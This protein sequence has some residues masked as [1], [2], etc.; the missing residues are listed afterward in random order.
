MKILMIS[1]V[2][3][4]KINGAAV[5]VSNMMGS[6]SRR[7]HKVTLVTRREE[8]AAAEETWNE[9]RVL[10]V[11]RPGFALTRRMSLA[12]S[13]FATG[14]R[15]S[16]E[17][18]PDVIHS[19]GFTSLLAGA[20][21]GMIL[22]RPVVVSF[23]GIQRLWSSQ[24]RWR[25]PIT[26]DL[27]YPIEK[28]LLRATSAILAQSSL[29]RDVVVQ[30][31]SVPARK[32]YV[33]PNPVDVKKFGFA[34]LLA[35]ESQVVLF[36]GSLMRVHGPDILVEAVPTILTGH[37]KVKVVLVG[38]GPLKEG[39]ER[40]I[41]ELGLG[42]SVQLL[43]EVGDQTRLSQIYG[44]A[45]VVVIPLRYTGYILSLV[46]EE[47]MAS[48]R[49]FVTTMTLDEELAKFGVLQ[50]G[51]NGAALGT[52]ISSVLDWKETRYDEV[53]R[54]ARAYAEQNFSF[55]AV[56][57]ALESVYLGATTS[58]RGAEVAAPA[59]APSPMPGAKYDPK[60]FLSTVLREC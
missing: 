21:L 58:R 47:A 41:A 5:A 16:R 36:V 28:T 60:R 6:L 1:G 40:R 55:E 27:I 7:G 29:L 8:G 45:Y 51:M 31:Y 48:G 15:V 33:V 43:E 59:I 4:P 17:D 14:L 39:L 25:N 26:F 50:A 32:V 42:D 44:S 20:L 52:A 3:Y 56:G 10:R 34:P 18:P 46:G 38:R 19:H 9:A 53:S 37:S 30:V 11:G 49:P 12:F 2:F 23:H 54:A 24:A 22:R 57:A 35:R 13:M